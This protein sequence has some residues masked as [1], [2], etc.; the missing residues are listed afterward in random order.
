MSGWSDMLADAGHACYPSSKMP[1]RIDVVLA[2]RGARAW[3]RTARIR[4]GLGLA[5]HAA[6]HVDLEVRPE[7]QAHA[8]CLREPLIGPERGG[9]AQQRHTATDE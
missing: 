2:S 3:V 4:W 8:Q 1:S 5:T 9:W 7:E 6:L